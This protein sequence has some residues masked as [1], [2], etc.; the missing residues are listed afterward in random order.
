MCSPDGKYGGDKSALASYGHSLTS[1]TNYLI[2]PVTSVVFNPCTLLGKVGLEAMKRCQSS[3]DGISR[4]KKTRGH[5][6]GLRRET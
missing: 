5:L 6:H 1:T 3:D 4:T 2:I